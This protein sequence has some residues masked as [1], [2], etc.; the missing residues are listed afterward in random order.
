MEEKENIDIKN[1]YTEQDLNMMRLA[2]EAMQAGKSRV[3]EIKA[4]AKKAGIKRIGIANC[5]AVQKEADRLKD[6]LS[7]DFEVYSASCKIDGIPRSVFIGETARGIACNPAGQALYLDRNG[8]ELNISFGLCMGHD[9]IFN[10]KSK[11]PVTTLVV[12]D[13]KYRHNPFQHFSEVPSEKEKD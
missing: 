8:T 4:Y 9:I 7:G 10:G 5:M 3:D 1:L 2:D 12:K 11:A 13:R 6:M